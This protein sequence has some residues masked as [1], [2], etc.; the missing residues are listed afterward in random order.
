MNS[1][2]TVT[3]ALSGVSEKFNRRLRTLCWESLDEGV[4][5][6]FRLKAGLEKVQ[7][8]ARAI[9]LHHPHLLANR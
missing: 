7:Q 8:A 9:S 3:V 4:L 6:F 2:A 1:R 5:L